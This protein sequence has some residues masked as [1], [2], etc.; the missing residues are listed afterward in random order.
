MQSNTDSGV[1]D[2][3]FADTSDA[4]LAWT[5]ASVSTGDPETDNILQDILMIVN[6]E[7]FGLT[8]EPPY[9]VAVKRLFM[10]RVTGSTKQTDKQV[11]QS[12]KRLI[13]VK[14]EVRVLT[15]P[16]LR[17]HSCLIS[18]I[19]WGWEPDLTFGNRPYLVM[20]YSPHGTL[21]SFSQKRGL[22]LIDRRFLT[23]D[24]AMGIRALHD[25]DIV[26]GDVKPDNVLVYGYFIRDKDEDRHYLGRPM[27]RLNKLLYIRNYVLESLTCSSAGPN[28][29]PTTHFEGHHASIIHHALPHRDAPK[30]PAAT[31]AQ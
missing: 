27:S 8:G 5:P 28:L 21:A 31:R 20:P 1:W 24:V 17:S 16:R 9:F 12:S 13:N 22:N 2:S 14:R 23:L 15:H 29:L 10:D 11:Q 19:A 4:A 18:A 6:K 7:L 3:R 25:C 30:K 26:H